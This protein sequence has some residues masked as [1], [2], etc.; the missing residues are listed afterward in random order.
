MRPVL[1]DVNALIALFDDVHIFNRS[2]HAW[3]ST[4]LRR[5]WRTCPIT[6][7]GLIRIMSHPAYSA[8]Q[9]P[10]EE[11]ANRLEELKLNSGSHQF[12]PDSYSTSKWLAGTHHSVPSGRLTDAYLLRLAELH[13][14][15]LAT[16]DKR[17]TTSL[18]RSSDSSILEFI[19]V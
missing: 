17:I 4:A 2:V 16:F 7:N 18:I 6:E 15:A 12:C 8:G 11:L 10:A 13:G 9:T 1:L 14:F 5:G 3:F 19:P